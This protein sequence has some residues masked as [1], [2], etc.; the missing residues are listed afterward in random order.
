M[1]KYFIESVGM[2]RFPL[3][4]TRRLYTKPKVLRVFNTMVRSHRTKEVIIAYTL[5]KAQGHARREFRIAHPAHFECSICEKAFP[6]EAALVLHRNNCTGSASGKNDISADLR[7]QLDNLFGSEKGRQLQAKRLMFSTDLGSFEWRVDATRLAKYRPHLA[8]DV[9]INIKGRV[10]HLVVHNTDP[11]GIY[12]NTLS[13]STSALEQ[14]FRAR[15]TK[16][17][18][19]EDILFDLAQHRDNAMDVVISTHASSHAEVKFLW[20]GFAERSI[21]IVG[22][23]PFPSA[24]RSIVTLK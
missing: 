10:S 21:Q 20:R 22:M 24:R 1:C 14:Q 7:A 11:K 18:Y 9:D 13:S 12:Q 23:K 8:E 2:K 17:K 5:S 6:E 15:Y 3:H 16:S 19:F 4:W